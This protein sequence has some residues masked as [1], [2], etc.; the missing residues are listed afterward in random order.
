[1][2]NLDVSRRDTLDLLAMVRNDRRG[3]DRGKIAAR[4]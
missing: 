2:E 4:G 3:R 1:M